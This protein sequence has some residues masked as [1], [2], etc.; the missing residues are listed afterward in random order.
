MGLA[1]KAVVAV[2]FSLIISTQGRAADDVIFPMPH[3]TPQPEGSTLE[4]MKDH[5]TNSNKKTKKS[6]APVVQIDASELPDVGLE[7]EIEV[8]KTALKRQMERCKA[9]D[10]N[11]TWDFAGRKVT[12]KE[13]C[14]DT[15]K[16][17]LKL[18]E[19]Y[20]DFGTMWDAARGMFN[21]YRSVGSPDYENK[22]LFTG[23]Y[24][25]LIDAS[26]TKDSRFK[27][28]I[29]KPSEDGSHRRYTR[30]QIDWGNKLAGKNLEIAYADNPIS[31][32]F[33]HIQ[34]SGILR[35]HQADGRFTKQVRV[36]YADQNGKAYTA[37]G[38][39]L[40][41]QGVEKKY[42]SSLQGLRAYFVK[43]PD[44]I[45]PVFA[46]D[47][48]Y[49]FFKEADLNSGPYG[50]SGAILAPRHSIATDNKIFPLGA[51]GLISAARVEKAEDAVITEETP[52]TRF[53]VN[54]D[55][56][57]AI[58]GAGRVDIFWGEDEFAEFTAGFQKHKGELIFALLPPKAH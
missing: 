58:K 12:R 5:Q 26:R 13:W 3:W 49:V 41:E 37:I 56:G 6:S 31:V 15:A 28:P 44:Q 30:E 45:H 40:K 14:I 10:I 52:F 39:V 18:A 36:N 24:V 9:Q 46:K 4:L 27:Y 29:Y 8:F 48:S 55:T 53:M 54:Q 42:W 50:S 25:P 43:Y 47:Q 2:I 51:I 20:N 33:L 23:Y 7:G 19:S 21:W 1:N 38:N 32:F 11:A 57:G 34:G 35:L 22:V 16:A 17:F